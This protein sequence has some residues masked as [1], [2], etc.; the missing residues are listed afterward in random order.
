MEYHSEIWPY[1]IRNLMKFFNYG[2]DD[3]QKLFE[4]YTIAQL[5]EFLQFC[6]ERL[7]ET[8]RVLR[9]IYPRAHH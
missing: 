7:G 2:K 5:T 8:E 6:G 4:P 3:P 1:K 9:D